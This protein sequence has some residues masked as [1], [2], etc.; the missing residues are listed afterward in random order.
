MSQQEVYEFNVP[1]FGQ[2]RADVARHVMAA[3]GP[4]PR[5][6]W[7]SHQATPGS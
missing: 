7:A 4:E 5:A 3:T 1:T 6:A 2:G